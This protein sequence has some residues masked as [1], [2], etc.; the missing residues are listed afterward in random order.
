MR[1]R[2]EER[3]LYR[4]TQW[5]LN[6]TRLLVSGLFMAVLAGQ[7]LAEERYPR[8]TWYWLLILPF[9]LWYL[10]AGWPGRP[11]PENLRQYRAHATAALLLWIPCLVLLYWQ[12]THAW[13]VIGIG[14]VSALAFGAA[15]KS[16]YKLRA[17]TF[18]GWILAVPVVFRLAWPNTQRFML[19]L[20]LG[21]L[22]IALQGALNFVQA[23]PGAPGSRPGFGRETG[24]A[25]VQTSPP[26]REPGR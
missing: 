26:S 5:C 25:H 14:F 21:G 4:S 11:T 16:L 17:I 23:L 3:G 19:V 20:V 9:C 1:A 18:A 13:S 15:M 12:R 6:E 10:W 8:A 2:G 7:G 24:G 22:A